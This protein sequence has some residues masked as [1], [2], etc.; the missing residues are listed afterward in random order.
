MSDPIVIDTP[1]DV[2]EFLSTRIDVRLDQIHDALDFGTADAATVT[3]HAA[4]ASFGWRLW[5]GVLTKLRDLKVTDAWTAERPDGLEVVRRRDNLVQITPSTG[6]PSTG[7]RDGHP[8]CKYPRGASSAKAVDRNQ[9]SFDAPGFEPIRT[10]WLLWRVFTKRETDTEGQRWW[11]RAE[12]SL[13]T[14][15][16][17]GMISGW[18]YRLIVGE[19]PF[20]TVRTAPIPQPAP[21]P[22]ITLPRRA[23]G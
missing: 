7:L 10:W 16:S 2:A 1:A 5:D 12:L 18:M 21:A 22:T 13:P 14:T 3:D 11:Y 9:M 15:I 23:E 6:S 4:Q 20:A 17:D 19:R 8:T